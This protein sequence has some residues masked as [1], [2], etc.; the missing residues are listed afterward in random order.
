MGLIEAADVKHEREHWASIGE[1]WAVGAHNITRPIVHRHW[2]EIHKTRLIRWCC[3]RYSAI[4][5]ERSSGKFEHGHLV[6]SLALS[7]LPLIVLMQLMPENSVL[8][9]V[10]NMVICTMQ[11][12]A[13]FCNYTR[14][15]VRWGLVMAHGVVDV[16]WC[17]PTMTGPPG[18]G[19]HNSGTWAV[20]YNWIWMNFFKWVIGRMTI[21]IEISAARWAEQPIVRNHWRKLQ[22]MRLDNQQTLGEGGCKNWWKKHFCYLSDCYAEIVTLIIPNTWLFNRYSAFL[23]DSIDLSIFISKYL[24][25]RF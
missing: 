4:W 7:L 23:I 18:P 1:Y 24:K 25:E 12:G 5:A 19:F 3:W 20:T 21:R 14:V 9:I 8:G 11:N 15:M 22:R 2:A 13:Y 10:C 6:R 17:S 16:G